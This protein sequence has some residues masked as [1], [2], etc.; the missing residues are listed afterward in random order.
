M[1]AK[2]PD[3]RYQQADELLLHLEALL[4]KPGFRPEQPEELERLIGM[5]NS[6]QLKLLLAVA[7]VALLLFLFFSHRN[8]TNHQ[9]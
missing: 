1:L 8:G 3:Q 6:R 5:R 7:V 9:E 4:L 2:M